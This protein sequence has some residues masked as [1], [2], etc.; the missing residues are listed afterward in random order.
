MVLWLSEIHNTNLCKKYTCILV[1]LIQQLCQQQVQNGFRFEFADDSSEFVESEKLRFRPRD[2]MPQIQF[3]THV[4]C[5]QNTKIV[6]IITTHIATKLTGQFEL[7]NNI[8]QEQIC[9]LLDLPISFDSP[10]MTVNSLANSSIPYILLTL[11]FLIVESKLAQIRLVYST[12]YFNWK[13]GLCRSIF[14]R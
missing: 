2:P 9:K 8:P 3:H 7:G 14:A 12:N 10:E 1:V 5:L 11:N 6:F 13:T 4:C